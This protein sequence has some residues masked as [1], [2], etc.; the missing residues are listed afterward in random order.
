MQTLQFEKAWERTISRED[1]LMITN[2][3]AQIKHKTAQGIEISYLW[4]AQNHQGDL[5]M[6]TFIHNYSDEPIRL[7]NT[8]IAYIKNEQLIASG[9]FSVP[10]SVPSQTT[11]PWTFIFSDENLTDEAPEV[12]IKYI[13]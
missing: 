4:E 2:Q 7:T 9:K 11:M 10:E 3:F 6:T 1:R 8:N 12:F 5:L 13:D